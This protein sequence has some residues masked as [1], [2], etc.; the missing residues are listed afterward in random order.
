MKLKSKY[1]V[2]AIVEFFNDGIHDYDIARINGIKMEF[3][4][5]T[6]QRTSYYVSPFRKNNSYSMEIKEHQIRK[7]LNK[8]AFERVYAEQCAKELR[9]E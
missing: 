1:N 2:G 7:T 3:S 6:L 4:W 5:E 8:K 9:D